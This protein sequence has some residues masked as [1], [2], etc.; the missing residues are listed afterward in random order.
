MTTMNMMYFY[1]KL[2]MKFEYLERPGSRPSIVHLEKL[3]SRCLKL[4]EQIDSF[5]KIF[6]LIHVKEEREQ[7]I[8]DD[9]NMQ[10]EKEERKGQVLI[11]RL[12]V[13]ICLLL[14]E[15]PV[16]PLSFNFDG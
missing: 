10:T 14:K 13:A 16:L 6:K 9:L 2:K 15:N 11:K 3:M 8:N 4:Y 5:M 7:L 12:T 1:E